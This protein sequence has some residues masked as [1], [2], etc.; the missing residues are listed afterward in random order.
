MSDLKGWQN[1]AAELYG[2]R[3]IPANYLVDCATGKIVA[4]N[5]RGEDVKAKIA[6]LLK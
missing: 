4:S 5:L 3:S 1:S 2:V 6:E